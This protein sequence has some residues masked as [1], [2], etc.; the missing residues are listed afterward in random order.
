MLHQWSGREGPPGG[1]IKLA[2]GLGA[3]A[4]GGCM[5]NPLDVCKT[6]AQVRYE[7]RALIIC[8]RYE[9]PK[10][11]QFMSK[12][13]HSLSFLFVLSV[14][15]FISAARSVV[16]FSLLCVHFFGVLFSGTG[17]GYRSPACC[18]QSRPYSCACC[19]DSRRRRAGT[20]ERGKLAS[21]IDSLQDLLI[22]TNSDQFTLPVSRS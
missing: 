10:K 4:L 15:H 9:V 14:V 6:R 5:I 20:R 7:K 17:R 3:G 19:F 11:I 13:D 21:S 16:F 8:V 22:I 18:I 12:N 1:D 2:A